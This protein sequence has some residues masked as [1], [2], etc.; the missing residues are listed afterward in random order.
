M[1]GRVRSHPEERVVDGAGVPRMPHPSG[2]ALCRWQTRLFTRRIAT[3]PT[4][5]DES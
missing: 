4:S 1:S 2:S 5:T 3:Y